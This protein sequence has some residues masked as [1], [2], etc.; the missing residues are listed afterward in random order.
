MPS[1]DPNKPRGKNPRT[2][3]KKKPEGPQ[4]LI[5]PQISPEMLE[6]ARRAGDYIPGTVLPLAPETL[7]AEDS[8]S[9]QDPLGSWTGVPS[10]NEYETPTQ[11][12]DDL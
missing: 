8:A 12:A 11:D 5:I 4:T 10:D 3:K 9:R 7:A 1:T 6:S 2:G